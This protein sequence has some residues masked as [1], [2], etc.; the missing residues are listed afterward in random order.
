MIRRAFYGKRDAS[1]AADAFRNI[2]QLQFTGR[3][4]DPLPFHGPTETVELDES[5]LP[6][7]LREGD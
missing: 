1:N 5:E 7:E 4:A 3:P 2:G 6:W